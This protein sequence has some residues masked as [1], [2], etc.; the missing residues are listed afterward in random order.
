MLSCIDKWAHSTVACRGTNLRIQPSLIHCCNHVVDKAWINIH[1]R[2]C[3]IWI[4][5]CPN[6]I[7]TN[8]GHGWCARK[9]KIK[10][11]QNEIVFKDSTSPGDQ[12]FKIYCL[13]PNAQTANGSTAKQICYL[14][15]MSETAPWALP[16]LK[17]HDQHL[18][19]A[20]KIQ[21][22]AWKPGPAAI[23]I[24]HAMGLARFPT[25]MCL[26]SKTHVSATKSCIKSHTLVRR[27]DPRR[28][29]F[30]SSA[31]ALGWSTSACSGLGGARAGVVW[32]ALGQGL[33]NFLQRRF[34]IY[35]QF[36]WSLEPWPFSKWC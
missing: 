8:I 15:L 3:R 24:S 19:H 22:A 30:C 9:T 7:G 2:A 36:V 1:P 18:L 23:W 29:C 34:L 4:T 26:G 35:G 25:I 21:W 31:G 13:E 20:M 16:I 17:V 27:P 28:A 32:H 5:I 12:S 14:A 33:A 6:G 10:Q 11:S